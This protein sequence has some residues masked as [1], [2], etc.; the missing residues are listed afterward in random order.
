MRHKKHRY[1]VAKGTTKSKRLAATLLMTLL[2]AIRK[3]SK[4]CTNIDCL[5]MRYNTFQIHENRNF[6]GP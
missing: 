4:T 1:G 2:R 5:R 3:Y 6:H